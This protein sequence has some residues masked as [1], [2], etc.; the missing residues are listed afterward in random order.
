MPNNNV[1]SCASTPSKS[2]TKHVVTHNTESTITS[3]QSQSQ[4]QQRGRKLDRSNIISNNNTNT[5]K[6]E[7]S[8]LSTCVSSVVPFKEVFELTR[9]V[10]IYIYIVFSLVMLKHISCSYLLYCPIVCIYR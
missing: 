8:P 3:Q 5:M 9:Q 1:V 4:Q 2:S 10:S 7:T 6:R